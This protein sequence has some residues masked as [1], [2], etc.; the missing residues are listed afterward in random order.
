MIP[1]LA[2]C[3][4]MLLLLVGAPCGGEKKETMTEDEAVAYVRAYLHAKEFG[5]SNCLDHLEGTD[6]V[7][8]PLWQDPRIGGNTPPLHWTARRFSKDEQLFIQ[9]HVVL[10][11]AEWLRP[12]QLEDYYEVKLLGLNQT[13][14][15]MVIWGGGGTYRRR[16]GRVRTRCC[17]A[18]NTGPSRIIPMTHG[19]YTYRQAGSQASDTKRNPLNL[20][21]CVD[22]RPSGGLYL[23]ATSDYQLH[24]APYPSECDTAEARAD[25]SRRTNHCNLERP[26]G[27]PW[28]FSAAARRVAPCGFWG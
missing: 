11:R 22:T 10:D 8:D 28:P 2:A 9:R 16:S 6:E 7:L 18:P 26:P 5:W 1:W 24:R 21:S 19:G 15:Q 13:F 20:T 3:V 25:G 27:T 23:M 14:G 17:G 12:E 4:A